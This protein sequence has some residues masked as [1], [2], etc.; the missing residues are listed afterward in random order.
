MANLLYNSCLHDEARG[1]ID[2]DTGA[3]YVMLVGAAYVPDIDAHLDKADVTSEVTGTGYTA[4]GKVVAVTVTKSTATDSVVVE[5]ESAS[6]ADAGFG[7]AGA[8]YYQLATPLADSRL[9][10]YVGFGGT[11]TATGGTF[12]V[13]PVTLTKQNR[14]VVI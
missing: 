3:F 4:G 8:V 11:I 9:V 6:W 10:G 7:A 1:L 2:F 14:S 12:S 5:F 13:A